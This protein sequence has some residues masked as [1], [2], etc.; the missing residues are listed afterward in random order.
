[1]LALR[2]PSPYTYC[3]FRFVSHEH[4]QIIL[5]ICELCDPSLE[6]LAQAASLPQTLK[7]HLPCTTVI[8]LPSSFPHSPTSTLQP[9]PTSFPAHISLFTTTSSLSI[10]SQLHFAR[11]LTVTNFIRLPPRACVCVSASVLKST[12]WPLASQLLSPRRRELPSSLEPRLLQPRYRRVP[13]PPLMR[14]REP[15]WI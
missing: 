1:M 14:R 15:S 2:W 6:H 4:W 7:S 9:P 10:V 12:W 3:N 11:N 8:V 13:L 5:K